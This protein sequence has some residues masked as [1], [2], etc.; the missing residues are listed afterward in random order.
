MSANPPLAD[1]R[2]ACLLP[3]R[4]PPLSACAR[5]SAGVSARTGGRWWR[6]WRADDRGG[7]QSGWISRFGRKAE[8]GAV[9]RWAVSASAMS[10][11]MRAE[12]ADG[13]GD[14]GNGGQKEKVGL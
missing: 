2:L 7:A 5:P 6:R 8:G 13:G 3:G 4:A 11:V 1:I 10:D 9:V 14:G 12:A